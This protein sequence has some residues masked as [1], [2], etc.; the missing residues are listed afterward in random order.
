MMRTKLIDYFPEDTFVFADGFDEAIIGLDE[1]SMRIVY[2]VS[3]CISILERD[4]MNTEEAEE[5]F[6]FNV[7]GAY[8]GEKTPIWCTDF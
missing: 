1:S 6:L 3:K 5:Y 8:V 2:S 4:G 7:Y